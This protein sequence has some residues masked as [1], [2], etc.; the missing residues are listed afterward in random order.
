MA[1]ETG[2]IWA[3]STFNAWMG[4]TKCSPA[5]DHCYAENLMDTRWKKVEWGPGKPRLRTSVD[6]WRTPL[7]WND[8]AA[9]TGE[10]WP[11]FCSSLSDVFDNEVDPGWRRDLFELIGE[12][13]HLTW[14]LLTK[15]VGNATNMINAALLD[16]GPR[17]PWPNVWIGATI[18]NQ[19]EADRDIPKLLATPAAKRFVSI[20]PMLGSIDLGKF[21]FE[22]C[23][24]F[25]RDDYGRYGNREVCCGQPVALEAL[26]W[27][28][29]G[30]ESGSQARPS[31]PDWFRSLRD[32]CASAGVPFLFK[33]WGEWT[34]G[35]C[36]T[37]QSGTVRTA[38]WFDGAWQYGEESLARDDGHIDDEPDVYRTGVKAAGNTLD[39]RQHVAFP[40]G[41]TLRTE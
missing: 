34:P 32:Q 25:E 27:V 28:I 2:I 37:Q 40:D 4:C 11:V 12:T 41:L 17:W 6:N 38:T 3:K 1:K 30:G 15:R 33:Q 19:A 29:A 22:C 14:L 21:L 16:D 13:P 36:V 35:E 10:F 23:G 8:E 39:G 20:E 7:R 5:C 26:D 9:K 31:H 18:C 24:Q